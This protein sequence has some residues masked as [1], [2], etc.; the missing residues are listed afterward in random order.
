M[1]TDVCI[2]G[3]GFTGLSAA[4]ELGK[5]SINCVVLDAHRIGWGASGRNGGQLGT[6]FNMDQVTLASLMG[7]SLARSLWDISEQA[8]QWVLDTCKQ[9]GHDIEFQRGI[10]HALHRERFVKPA[11]EYCTYLQTHYGYESLQPL[12]AKTIRE[13]VNSDNY[14]GGTMDH[15]AGHIH[16]LKLAVALADVAESNGANIY[17]CSEATRIQKATPYTDQRVVT[18]MGS[19]SCQHVILATNGYI[20]DLHDDVS[21]RLM[22]INNFIVVTEP[23]GNMASELLP[24]NDAIADSRFVVNYYRRVAGDR[25]LFGGG[26]NYSYDFPDPIAPLVR[27]AMLGVFPQLQDT[28]IDYAW[29]GTLA[30]TRNRLPYLAQIAPR[31]FTAGGYSGHGVA[32]ACIYGKALADHIAG[33]SALFD[34]LSQLPNTAFPGNSRSRPLLLAMA[35]TGYSWLDRI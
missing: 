10:V 17:E 24:R 7:E 25:L 30:I 16:S 11:H 23:L 12:D 3:A 2:I 31:Q 18:P 14:H 6:G 21:K 1:S 27:R 26:E 13:H 28:A 32:L 19:V 4:V 34:V 5:H 22:P 15:G 9:N 29:G 8:K 20:D 33:D 35:M